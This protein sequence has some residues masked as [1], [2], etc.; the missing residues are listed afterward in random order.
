MPESTKRMRSSV[1]AMNGE[2]TAAFRFDRFVSMGCFALA[3]EIVESGHV[4]I[5]GRV[6]FSGHTRLRHVAATGEVD[7]VE[8]ML[9]EGAAID[10]PYEMLFTALE[11]E[12]NV[13]F[14][15][16]LEYG[17]LKSGTNFR[18][19]S[20]WWSVF[21]VHLVLC[22]LT[23]F[24]FFLWIVPGA[25]LDVVGPTNKTLMHFNGQ[26]NY[27]FH[28]SQCLK[29]SFPVNRRRKGMDLPIFDAVDRRDP[30]AFGIMVEYG[31]ADVDVMD[32]GNNHLLHRLVAMFAEDEDNYYDLLEMI[33]ICVAN[34]GKH[35]NLDSEIVR[36]SI[37]QTAIKV[38][39]VQAFSI[40]DEHVNDLFVNDRVLR[41]AA[42]SGRVDV[43]WF[44]LKKMF[45]SDDKREILNMALDDA[46]SDIME[47]IFQVDAYILESYDS[48]RN[49][50]NDDGNLMHALMNDHVQRMKSFGQ[51]RDLELNDCMEFNERHLDKFKLLKDVAAHST[52]GN[53]NGVNGTEDGG[54]SSAY[55]DSED[56]D[57]FGKPRRSFPPRVIDV[58][59]TGNE[60]KFYKY[61]RI[62]NLIEHLLKEYQ[63][64]VARD[65]VQQR[66][67]E[68]KYALKR[69]SLLD[70]AVDKAKGD[71]GKVL[72]RDCVRKVYSCLSNV[73]LE[74]YLYKTFEN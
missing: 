65:L 40:I 10:E 58:L 39:P 31:G 45:G 8:Y 29:H 24:L 21:F 74:D 44:I 35:P 15:L 37:I 7:L 61:A 63:H 11:R 32:R 69:K 6:L 43:V 62:P 25:P 9:K 50:I 33:S 71:V 14:D 60:H 36:E 66:A 46:R 48:W 17:K 20:I 57:E 73:E 30:R 53:V 18:R 27:C 70:K 13:M 28:V 68:L 64:T 47:R 56:A 54:Y 34:M 26:R 49:Y 59:G 55:S 22:I 16:L 19:R 72:N 3:K 1:K 23:L 41:L 4:N 2:I 38:A 67:F 51:Y 42:D 12:D 5:E 52:L